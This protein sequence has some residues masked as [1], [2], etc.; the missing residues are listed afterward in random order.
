MRNAVLIYVCI[1]TFFIFCP[2]YSLTFNHGLNEKIS[3]AFAK[4]LFWSWRHSVSGTDLVTCVYLDVSVSCFCSRKTTTK[5]NGR[6]LPDPG[7]YPPLWQTHWCINNTKYSEFYEFFRFIM[8][9]ILKVQIWI[10]DFSL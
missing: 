8:M 5:L 2:S 6:W 3:P 1:Y 4:L 10:Q 7:Y 9:P